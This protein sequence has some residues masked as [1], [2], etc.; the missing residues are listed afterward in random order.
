[1]L[2]NHLLWSLTQCYHFPCHFSSD[3]MPPTQSA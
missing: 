2:Q 3:S 1:L